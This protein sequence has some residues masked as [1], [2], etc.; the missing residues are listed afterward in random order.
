MLQGM[1]EILELKYVVGGWPPLAVVELWL[2]TPPG[3]GSSLV[4]FC[5]DRTPSLYNFLH[6]RQGLLDREISGEVAL[7]ASM[8][9]EW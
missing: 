9:S 8:T 1:L 5:R 7:K 3:W 4:A 2:Y 6:G